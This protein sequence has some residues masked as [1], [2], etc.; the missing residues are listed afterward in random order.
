M[1]P[2]RTPRIARHTAS[3]VNERIRQRTEQSVARY[4]NASARQ[5]ERRLGALEREWDIERVIEASAAAAALVGFAAGAAGY[6]RSF[7]LPV[8][9]AGFLL[10][11]ALQGWSPPVPLLRRLGVRTLAEIQEERAALRLLYS[12]RAS[13]L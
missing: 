7:A 3:A 13:G 5:I 4:L 9:V 11:H 8:V 1:L 10:Q 6:R 12:A 2:V